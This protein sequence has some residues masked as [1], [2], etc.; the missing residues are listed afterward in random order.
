MKRARK[1]LYAEAIRKYYEQLVEN[2]KSVK[3]QTDEEETE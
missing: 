3:P 1:K 2:A